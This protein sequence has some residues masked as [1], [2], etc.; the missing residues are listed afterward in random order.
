[1]AEKDTSPSV[2]RRILENLPMFFDSI[3]DKYNTGN[4]SYPELFKSNCINLIADTIERYCDS[5]TDSSVLEKSLIF[6]NSQIG[7]I[8]LYFPPSPYT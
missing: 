7:S 6:L 1:M 2:I 8:Y 4:Y 5:Q 3:R